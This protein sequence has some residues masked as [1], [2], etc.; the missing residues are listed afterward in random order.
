MGWTRCWLFINGRH[1]T[2][3]RSI[4]AVKGCRAHQQLFNRSK[5]AILVE[6]EPITHLSS[7]LLHTVAVLPP[8]WPVLFLGSNASTF[9]VA[10]RPAIS[11]HAFTGKITISHIPHP[12]IANDTESLSRMLTDARFYNEVLPGVEWL[13][14]LSQDSVLCANSNA[15]LNEWLQ[16]DWSGAKKYYSHSKSL[17]IHFQN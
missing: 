14:R 10:R 2:S 6:T 3:L 11:R 1:P 17:V 7:L 5:L 9:S 12:W 16:W 4:A 15:S 13:L 8:E